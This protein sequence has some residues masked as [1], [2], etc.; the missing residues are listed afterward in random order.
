MLQVGSTAGT[1]RWCTFWHPTKRGKCMKRRSRSLP[2]RV[3]DCN[4]KYIITDFETGAINAAKKYFPRAK[5]HA[6]FFHL[7]QSVWRHIQHLGLQ[8]RYMSDPDYAKNVRQL[9]ALA[10]VPPA[11][12]TDRFIQLCRTPFWEEN[13]DPDN[14]K[15]QDLLQYFEST[16]IGSVG[17]NGK[18]KAVQFPPEIWSV[19]EITVLGI[20]RTNN[21]L[22]AW[23]GV[24]AR[25]IG[26]SHSTIFKF[27]IALQSEQNYQDLR[28]AKIE[29]GHSP[30]VVPR[31][32][33]EMNE[34]LVKTCKT[35]SPNTEFDILMYL[36]KL[37][38]NFAL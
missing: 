13:D 6:C 30:E 16:Y 12:I 23:H 36:N 15:L 22:E 5:F 26:A 31:S 29:S 28:M 27:L 18:R 17:R 9:L 24:L 38:F 32:Y 8:T 35:Y 4:P 21:S 20:P 2:K 37:A 19:H 33:R 7:C 14:G 1:F 34:R 11:D 10:F 3:P 25:T